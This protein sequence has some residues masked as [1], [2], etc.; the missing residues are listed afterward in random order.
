MNKRPA[1][2]IRGGP[3]FIATPVRQT[4]NPSDET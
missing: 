4:S 2:E 3:F 1:P